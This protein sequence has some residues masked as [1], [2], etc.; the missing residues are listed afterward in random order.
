MKSST[1]NKTIGGT[2][3]A[4]ILSSVILVEGGYVNDPLDPGGETKYGITEKIAREYGYQG[5]M[6]NLPLETA[7]NIY[8][9]LYVEEPNFD[10]FIEINPAVAHKLIDAGI[11]VGTV[12]VAVWLQQILNIYSKNGSEYPIIS[13]DGIIG[14]KTIDAYRAFENKRGK[15]KACTLILKALDSYQTQYYMS[16]TRYNNYLIGWMDKR[17]ENVPLDQCENYNLHIPF[18]RKTH[19]SK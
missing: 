5:E 16:L 8:N 2:I 15:V 1:A 13:V 18:I 12:R 9:T 14:K 4:A 6:K 17:I 10:S 19:E 11:N 7:L 3:I